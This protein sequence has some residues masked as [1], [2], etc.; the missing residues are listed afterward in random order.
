M[1]S[2]PNQ[3]TLFGKQLANCFARTKKKGKKKVKSL[4]GTVGEFDHRR[5][6]RR[7]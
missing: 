1:E 3:E 5:L 2:V 4:Q 6:Q 7:R